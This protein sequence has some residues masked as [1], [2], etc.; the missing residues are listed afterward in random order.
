T[1]MDAR[2][3]PS[4]MP[5]VKSCGLLLFRDGPPKSFLLMK[6][7]GRYDLPK[8]HLEGLETELECALRELQEET[9]ISPESVELDPNFRY[10]ETY[11]PR[12]RRFGGR[13]VEKTLVIFLGRLTKPVTRLRLTEHDSWE[14]FPWPPYRRLQHRTIDPLL[15]QVASH[16]ARQDG[17]QD[18]EDDGEE[19]RPRQV[20][21]CSKR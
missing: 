16:W 5:R 10:T 2:V 20:L 12:Y 1:A 9:G 13:R 17:T 4:S 6:L 19:A 14:W 15:A 7:P 18:V 8:G 11:F 3:P 21:A